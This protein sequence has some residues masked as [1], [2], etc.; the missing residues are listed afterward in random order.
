VSY[1]LRIICRSD[2]PIPSREL[3]EFILDGMCLED[4]DRIRPS[5]EVVK[6]AGGGW[7]DFG[8]SSGEQRPRIA[9]TRN[10]AADTI[11]S[12]ELSEIRE[13]LLAPVV[14]VRTTEVLA[15]LDGAKQLI[16]L[17]VVIE[18]ITDDD[19][20]MLDCLESHIAKHYDGIIYADAEGFYDNSLNLICKL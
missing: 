3:V 14:N 18:K 19:W 17:D 5:I 10:V 9:L 7:I 11:F 16:A 2:D 15:Y 20:E 1:Y 13:A 12:S 4:T 6:S 8:I